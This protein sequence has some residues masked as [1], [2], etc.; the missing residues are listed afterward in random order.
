VTRRDL[1]VG[2]RPRRA[3]SVAAAAAAG[4]LAVVPAA[5]GGFAGNQT[6]WI[7]IGILS[8]VTQPDRKLADYQWDTVPRLGWGGQAVVGGRAW[9]AGLRLWTA[10]T[11]QRLDAQDPDARSTARWTSLEVVG[12]RRLATLLGNQVAALASAGRV[13]LGYD[14]DRITFDVNG[15]PVTVVLEPVDEWIMGAGVSLQRPLGASWDLGLEI[16]RRRFELDTAHRDGDAI[17]YARESFGDWSARLAIA[18]R[19]GR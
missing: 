15:T 9:S 7:S 18:R 10:S 4:V 1:V 14:P 11:T 8:G 2:S 17:E 16:E 5:A 12:R 3:C 19:L 6:P 13:H